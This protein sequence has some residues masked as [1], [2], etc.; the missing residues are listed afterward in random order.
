FKD[1]TGY[2]AFGEVHHGLPEEHHEWFK[3][4]GINDVNKGE[5]YF[6]LDKGIHR[7][8]KDNGI[9]TKNSPLGKPWNRVWEDWM[10]NHEEAGAR[11]ILEQL[12]HMAEKA[13]IEQFRAKPKP[14]WLSLYD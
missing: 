5:F 6:D 11:Q 2:D 14:W 12:D 7:L 8:K 1:Y 13:G 3:D 4:H 9:H 10:E